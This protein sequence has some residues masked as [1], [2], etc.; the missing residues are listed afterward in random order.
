MR[1]FVVIPTYNEK[2]NI[3]S[4]L[5]GVLRSLPNAKIVVVDDASPDGTGDV[6]ESLK[7]R[8]GEPLHCIHRNSD[9][10]LGPSCIEGFRFALDHGADKIF[11]MDADGSHAPESLQALLESS[12][13]H[14]LVIGSRYVPSGSTP[15]WPLHRKFLSRCANFYARGVLGLPV[16]DVTS[17]FKCYDRS[18][19]T[20]ID[21]GSVSCKGYGFQVEI[22]YRT[23][24]A[25]FSISEIPITFRDRTRGVS[26]MGLSIASEGF[27]QVLKLRIGAVSVAPSQKSPSCE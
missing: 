17:G 2:D 22:V 27:T 10:G 16:R 14:D 6:V 24:C 13:T 18:I 20:R 12:E 23:H 15:D 8:Y 9:R 25:G 21:L 11:Q 3:R 7:E 26:K 1:V 5:E 19:L 4:I